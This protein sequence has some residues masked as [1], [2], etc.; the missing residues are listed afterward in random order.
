M[1]R[2]I[3]IIIACIISIAAASACAETIQLPKING[4]IGGYTIDSCGTP[5][6]GGCTYVQNMSKKRVKLL[7]KAVSDKRRA[8][9]KNL[10]LSFNL[11]TE[12]E[13]EV[14]QITGRYTT[15]QE[16]IDAA[17]RSTKPGYGGINGFNE[18]ARKNAVVDT[19]LV[20]PSGL[21]MAIGHCGDNVGLVRYLSQAEAQAVFTNGSREAQA[22]A[23]REAAEE[24]RITAALAMVEQQTASARPGEDGSIVVFSTY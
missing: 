13:C 9:G 10:E 3:S 15:G 21:K 5:M 11:W 12:Q 17:T 1:K 4:Q 24:Q 23:D 2:I 14:Y 16:A 6:D 18:K 8:K 7:K 20:F 19:L 22:R